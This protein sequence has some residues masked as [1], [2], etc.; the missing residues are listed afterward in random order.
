MWS[1]F[2]HMYYNGFIHITYIIEIIQKK[3]S[4]TKMEL[5]TSSF[6]RLYIL[7]SGRDL[8]LLA[9]SAS[10]VASPN[11]GGMMKYYCQIFT[12]TLNLMSA[13]ANLRS[14][15]YNISV[16]SGAL[17]AYTGAW[18]TSVSQPILFQGRERYALIPGIIK[19]R[20]ASMT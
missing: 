5:E 3:C 4:R 11:M 18:K 12:S 10:D 20:P 15:E 17:H 7:R 19:S 16:C 8:M 9:P 13:V 2:L 6:G 14:S 1:T